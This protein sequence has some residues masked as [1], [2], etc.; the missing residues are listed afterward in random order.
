MKCHEVTLMK[1]KASPAGV[2][3]KKNGSKDSGAIT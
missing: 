1:L 3:E 2:T